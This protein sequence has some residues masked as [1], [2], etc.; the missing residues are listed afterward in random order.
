VIGIHGRS[1]SEFHKPGQKGID[2]RTGVKL[3]LNLAI[4]INLFLDLAVKELPD[5]GLT[6]KSEPNTSRLKIAK[7]KLSQ[8]LTADVFF[9]G[10]EKH[11]LGN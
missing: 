11:T 1:E 9:Q 4:S 8:A 5:L 3:G 10:V 6:N 7:S 2:P